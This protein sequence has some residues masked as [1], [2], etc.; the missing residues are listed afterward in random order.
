MNDTEDGSVK[1]GIDSDTGAGYSYRD[2]SKNGFINVYLDFLLQVLSLSLSSVV[3]F[4][5]CGTRIA[6]ESEY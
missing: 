3:D 5:G 4:A 1:C 2:C 6:R